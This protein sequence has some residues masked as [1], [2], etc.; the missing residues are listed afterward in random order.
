MID[1]EDVE[2]DKAWRKGAL[3][4]LNAQVICAGFKL[5][6][7]RTICPAFREERFIIKELNKRCK[8]LGSER[9]LVEWV[10]WNGTNFDIPILTTR[11]LLYG[12]MDLYNALPKG[13]RDKRN[14]DMMQMV[15]PTMWNQ[16][17]SLSE[18][19]AYLKVPVKEGDITGKTVHDH[20]LKGNIKGI[21]KY[22]IQDV[23]A[24]VKLEE[25]FNLD[26]TIRGKHHLY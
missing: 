10:T 24:L 14:L 21:R 15:T 25:K 13:S 5:D 6:D 26:Y 23:Q 11:A 4:I 20:F 3:D 17:W 2:F 7:N 22:C 18:I 1:N 16:Y 19:C 12:Y 8:D 9:H